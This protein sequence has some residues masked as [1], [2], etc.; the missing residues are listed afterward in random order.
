ML[1]QRQG[2]LSVEC[3]KTLSQSL[4]FYFFGGRRASILQSPAIIVVNISLVI[5][6][7]AASS[8]FLSD[9]DITYV[10][11]SLNIII[12][13]TSDTSL[14]PP[15]LCRIA[16]FSIKPTFLSFHRCYEDEFEI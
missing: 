3:A 14:H 16:V 2:G 9:S 7:S 12:T 8:C 1:V 4:L 11:H 13:V 6:T 15:R 10:Y 5:N